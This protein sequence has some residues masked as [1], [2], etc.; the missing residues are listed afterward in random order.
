MRVCSES[1]NWS[2]VYPAAIVIVVLF[3]RTSAYSGHGKRGLG[4][5]DTEAR[6][7]EHLDICGAGHE[8]LPAY[9]RDE[10]HQCGHHAL[11]VCSMRGGAVSA[12]FVHGEFR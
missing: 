4:S 10:R 3:C 8:V 9:P 5:G 2:G 7:S 6:R 12:W 11:G 1:C